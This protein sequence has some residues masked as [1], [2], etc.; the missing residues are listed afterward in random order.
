MAWIFATRAARISPGWGLDGEDE[1]ATWP[2][3]SHGGHPRT[4]PIGSRADRTARPSR[5]RAHRLAGRPARV[6]TIQHGGPPRKRQGFSPSEWSNG[7]S[8]EMLGRSLAIHVGAN[9]I[10][11]ISGFAVKGFGAKVLSGADS[12]DHSHHSFV[13]SA[14]PRCPTWL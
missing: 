14:S 6:V 2:H 12:I 8:E 7:E 13:R 5:K 10:D 1:Q 4:A 11:L 3:G 9:L